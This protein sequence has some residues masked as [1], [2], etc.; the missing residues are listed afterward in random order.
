MCQLF[1]RVR[2]VFRK[3]PET[4]F[5]NLITPLNLGKI[6]SGTHFCTLKVVFRPFHYFGIFL[7]RFQSV[8]TPKTKSAD[9]PRKMTS[10]Q[11]NRENKPALKLNFTL[12]HLSGID[13]GCFGDLSTMSP[14][15]NAGVTFTLTINFFCTRRQSLTV[16]VVWYFF[17]VR[18]CTIFGN[19][20]KFCGQASPIYVQ[21]CMIFS[22]L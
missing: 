14:S 4:T 16:S 20:L 1:F 21:Y 5:I 17:V 12:E 6:T 7:S 10:N 3:K 8:K 9:L 2:E 15:T 13:F 11:K 18:Y 22:L 19:I